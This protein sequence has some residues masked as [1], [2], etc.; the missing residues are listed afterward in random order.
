MG[1]PATASV[2]DM[3]QYWRIPLSLHQ[4]GAW[5]GAHPPRGLRQSGSSSGSG[6]KG[7]TNL[8]YSYTDNRSDPA[9][10][11]AE[12][13]IGITSAGANSSIWRID[14]VALWMDPRPQR[15]PAVTKPLHVTAFGRCPSDGRHTD[16]VPP[17]P[18]DSLLPPGTPDAAL[19]CSFTGQ[20]LT[21]HR[22]LGAAA[23]AHL[24]ALAHK[25]SL[26]HVDGAVANCPPGLDVHTVV[27]FAYPNRGPSAELWLE[28]SGCPWISNGTIMVGGGGWAAGSAVLHAVAE[29]TR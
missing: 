25:I 11:Q 21:A 10:I 23:T 9:W 17:G 12:L 24:A 5:V 8:G 27:A 7:D 28:P 16:G 2:I 26:A 22:R 3:T 20:R 15:A 4:A 14:G 29:L 18:A 13:E 1:E 19:I 6:P